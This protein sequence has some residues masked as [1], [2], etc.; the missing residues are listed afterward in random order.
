[1]GSFRDEQHLARLGMELVDEAIAAG[2]ERMDD[3]EG[4]R[5]RRE[6]LL[7]AQVEMI[8]TP[9][10]TSRRSGSNRP[11]RATTSKVGR[12]AAWLARMP[13]P[14]PIHNKATNSK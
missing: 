12:S 10:G 2:L 1:M 7:D 11:S 5:P 3:D 6:N 9:G 4:P 14:R 13:W 8:L